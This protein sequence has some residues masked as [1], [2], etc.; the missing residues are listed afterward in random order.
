MPRKQTLTKNLLQFR[1]VGCGCNV[2]RCSLKW[3]KN[4]EFMYTPHTDDNFSFLYCV[5]ASLY[6]GDSY[7]EKSKLC[8]DPRKHKGIMEEMQKLVTTGLKFPLST[9]DIDEFERLNKYQILINVIWTDDRCTSVRREYMGVEM[10][11]NR[12]NVSAPDDVRVVNILYSSP[13]RS[14]H[15]PLKLKMLFPSPK[16][17]MLKSKE[18]ARLEICPNCLC[19]KWSQ[20]A[21]ET[22]LKVCRPGKPSNIVMSDNPITFIN[23][24][25]TTLAR[26]IGICDFETLSEKIY[27]SICKSY[28]CVCPIATKKVFAHKPFCYSLVFIDTIEEKIIF[29]RTYSGMDCMDDFMSTLDGM[30]D[31]LREY[32]SRYEPIIMTAEDESKYGKAKICD[33]CLHP[34]Q[35]HDRIVRDHDHFSGLYRGACHNKCN[36]SRRKGTT[37]PLYAHNFV[38]FDGHLIVKK[39]A[40]MKNRRVE[41]LARNRQKIRQIKLDTFFVFKDSLEFLNASLDSLVKL[42]KD[43]GDSFKYIYQHEKINEDSDRRDTR[44]EMFTRKGVMPYEYASSIDKLIQTKGIPPRASFYST[45]TDTSVSEQNYQF[46]KNFYDEFEC[47]N[48]LEYCMLYCECDTLLLSDVFLRTRKLLF[49]KFQLD[50]CKYLS[51][52]SFSYDVMLRMSRVS[53]D[54]LPDTDTYDFFRSSIRGGVSYISERYVNVHDT[55]LSEDAILDPNVNAN[56]SILYLDMNNLYG[57]GLC[58]PLPTGQYHWFDEKE[59]QDFKL[60]DIDSVNVGYTLEVDLLYPQDLHDYHDSYPLA[61]ENRIIPATWLSSTSKECHQKIY[62]NKTYS[63]KKLLTTLK[64]KRKYV[65]SGR[66]LKYYLEM[67]MVLDKIHRIIS[68]NQAPFIKM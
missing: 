59:I 32:V 68:Y 47:S 28:K 52:P 24:Q 29:K 50:A 66:N 36:L 41:L 16:S 9:T 30:L 10:F 58:Q 46:A 11:A 20:A 21:F 26:V 1:K 51:L 31:S 4:R 65:V 15:Y 45:L 22:H 37:V 2:G 8:R 6:C 13:E 42:M 56:S 19:R 23:I 39:L 12:Q 34:F 43:S 3:T 53:L 54:P 7:K 27:C 17:S 64:D 5:A 25:N 33:A 18:N 63:P 61:P 49:E 35:I 67:G 62:G 57:Y 60:S 40:K 55:P 44:A 38:G 48:L 14:Y